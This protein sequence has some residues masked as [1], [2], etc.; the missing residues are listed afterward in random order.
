MRGSANVL[1]GEAAPEQE[2]GSFA[3]QAT[4][5]EDLLA[6]AALREIASVLRPVAIECIECKFD[7]ITV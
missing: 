2:I 3:L 5:V 7:S 1:G 4:V 6:E